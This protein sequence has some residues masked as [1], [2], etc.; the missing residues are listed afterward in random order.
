MQPSSPHVLTFSHSLEDCCEL[1]C[2]PSMGKETNTQISHSRRGV[3]LVVACDVQ[4]LIPAL[5][6]SCTSRNEYWSGMRLWIFKTL[7]ATHR[8]VAESH[9]NT[10]V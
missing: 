7:I 5:P 4:R 6:R 3:G 2:R 9:I 10:T 8:A 1:D